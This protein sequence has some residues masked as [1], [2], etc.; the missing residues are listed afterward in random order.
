VSAA[1]TVVERPRVSWTWPVVVIRSAVSWVQVV[2]VSAV[3]VWQA[4]AV[5]GA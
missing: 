3:L 1:G 2:V 4:P 5:P